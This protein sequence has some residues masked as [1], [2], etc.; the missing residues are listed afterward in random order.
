MGMSGRE[1]QSKASAGLITRMATEKTSKLKD[2]INSFARAG[3]FWN[4]S[5][6]SK[7]RFSFHALPPF[8]LHCIAHLPRNSKKI[9]ES[10]SALV[11]P[12]LA[13]GRQRHVADASKRVRSSSL[14]VHT[15]DLEPAIIRRLHQSVPDLLWKA[16]EAV[17]G[18]VCPLHSAI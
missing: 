3:S 9:S 1:S 12:S 7:L 18:N 6:A 5:I 11:E 14:I 16:L 15:D 10:P 13:A 17:A 4:F 8:S 2:C